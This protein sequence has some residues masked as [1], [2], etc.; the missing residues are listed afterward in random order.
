MKTEVAGDDDERG[1]RVA[2]IA[3]ALGKDGH[4]ALAE[5]ALNRSE[6]RRE[7][8]APRNV[9]DHV[10]GIGSENFGEVWLE[11]IVTGKAAHDLDEWLSRIE[12]DNSCRSLPSSN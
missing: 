11:V 5:N 3:F 8:V 7:K 4:V 10:R 1:L 6:I 2:G 9:V 12:A